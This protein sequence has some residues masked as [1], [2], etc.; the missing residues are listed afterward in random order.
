MRHNV[1]GME[2]ILECFGW[3]ILCLEAF[4][5]NFKTGTGLAFFAACLMAFVALPAN[6][7]TNSARQNVIQSERYESS[8]CFRGADPTRLPFL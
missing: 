7:A 3:Q 4:F 2:S 8:Y 1:S 6:A 5:M